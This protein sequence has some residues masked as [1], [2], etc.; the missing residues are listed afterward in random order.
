M[1]TMY[2]PEFHAK[3]LSTILVNECNSLYEGEPGDGH[4]GVH[5]EITPEDADESDDRPAEKTGRR[6]EDDVAVFFEGGKA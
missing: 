4:Y 5:G 1:E 2:N 3:T 6:T